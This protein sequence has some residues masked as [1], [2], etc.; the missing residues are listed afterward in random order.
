MYRIAVANG[1]ERGRQ[2]F[3]ANCF[4]GD[5]YFS[6]S[7]YVAAQFYANI[8]G[9]PVIAGK[10][11]VTYIGNRDNDVAYLKA[12]NGFYRFSP[13]GDQSKPQYLGHIVRYDSK[14]G[15]GTFFQ[16][17]ETGT[18]LMRQETVSLKGTK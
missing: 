15:K 9:G 1:Y 18:R 11:L 8:S 10:G 6:S 3:L 12:Q 7:K 14:T 4:A 16:R 5:S 17:A 13:N 2:T